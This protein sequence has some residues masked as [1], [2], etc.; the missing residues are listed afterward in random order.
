MIWLIMQAGIVLNHILQ[1]Q[2]LNTCTWPHCISSAKQFNEIY[3]LAI[4]YLITF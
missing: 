3:I 4:L 2:L 1:L